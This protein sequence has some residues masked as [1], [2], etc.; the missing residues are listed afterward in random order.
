MVTYFLDKTESTALVR[1]PHVDIEMKYIHELYFF[2]TLDVLWPEGA[3]ILQV[4]W[5]ERNRRCNIT[6]PID[7]I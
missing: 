7:F 1:P 2:C 3:R 6:I 5:R 4:D